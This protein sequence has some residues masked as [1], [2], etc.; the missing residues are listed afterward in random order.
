MAV[1]RGEATSTDPGSSSGTGMALGFWFESHLE[2]RTGRVLS[3]RIYRACRVCEREQMFVCVQYNIMRERERETYPRKGQVGNDKT[4][5]NP[6]LQ[7][8]FDVWNWICLFA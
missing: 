8:G 3:D 5:I 1:T 6:P 4:W 2:L 7:L